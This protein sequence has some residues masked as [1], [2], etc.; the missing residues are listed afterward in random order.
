[1]FKILYPSVEVNNG[2]AQNC[3][4]LDWRFFLVEVINH[5]NNMGGGSGGEK[6][7]PT[8]QQIRM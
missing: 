4:L 5:Q 3:K 7:E 6:G 1:M 8:K 2:S